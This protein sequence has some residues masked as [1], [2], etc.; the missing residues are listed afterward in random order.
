M[1]IIQMEQRLREAAS[2]R[3]HCPGEVQAG[4]HTPGLAA[5]TG[6]FARIAAANEFTHL[7]PLF[8]ASENFPITD[9]YVELRV[10]HTRGLAQPLLLKQGKTI[11]EEQE[12]RY[13]QHVS[14]HI[15]VHQC[16]NI[17][18]HHRMVILGD[19]G[20]GKTSL[21]KYLCLEIATG[22]SER[23]LVP[24]FVPLRRYWLAKQQDA[25]LNLLHYVADNLLQEGDCPQCREQ[26]AAIEGLL[27]TLSGAEKAHVLFLLDGLDEIATH[28]QAIEAVSADIRQLGERFSWVLTSR[29][30][31]FFGDVGE[32]ICYEVVRLGKAGIE[33]LVSNWFA[34]SQ[35]AHPQS[36]QQLLLSQIDTNPRLRDMAGNPF[37]LTL[38]CH[39]QQQFSSRCLPLHRSD[40]YANILYLIR[41]QLWYVKKNNHLFREAE[42]A[43]LAR[44]CHYLYTDADNVPLQIFEYAHWDR[45]ALPDSPPD[46]DQ[47]FLSS[48]LIH[49]WRQGGDFHFTHLTFQEYLIAVHIA[50]QPFGQVK[51]HLFN[52]HW[53]MVYRFLAGIYS[54]QPDQHNLKALLE[55]V[56]SPVDQMGILYLEAAR[57]LI[58]ANVEDSTALL[59]YDLRECLWQLWTDSADYVRESA[60]EVLALL[61]PGYV[62][63]RLVELQQTCAQEPTSRNQYILL[64]SI[65]LLGLIYGTDADELILD[66][67]QA[68]QDSV[69]AMAIG[70]IAVKNMQHLRQSVID[71]YETDHE[72]HFSL[73]CNV[74]KETRHKVFS[75]CLRPYLQRKPA[76]VERYD[77]VFQALT[78]LGDVGIA[79]DLVQFAE[80]CSVA[81]LSYDLVEA[82]LS[83]HTPACMRWLEKMLQGAE[84][85]LR[86]TLIFHAIRY[87]LLDSARLVDVLVTSEPHYQDVYLTALLENVQKGGRLERVIIQTLLAMVAENSGHSIGALSV[88]EQSGAETLMDGQAL[89]QLKALCRC[90]I[91]HAD[92]ELV[93][94][95]IA[96]LSRFRDIQAYPKIRRLALS[97]NVHGVQSIAIQALRHYADLY[98]QEVRELL[99]ALYRDAHTNRMVAD[100]A[101]TVLAKMDVQA[102][103]RYL[104]NPDTRG[105]ITA[106]CAR[107]GVLLFE[108]SYIDNFGDRH[109]FHTPQAR[110]NP[111]IPAEDQLE[112]LRQA[113]LYALENNI[114][115]KTAANRDSP[116][117]ALFVKPEP[118]INENRFPDGVNVKTGNK[119]LRGEL[120]SAASAQKI[121]NRLRRISP[122][123]F[124]D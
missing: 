121:M 48:R 93:V 65:R 95:S 87:G 17:P 82:L 28:S 85:E 44:F 8:D 66:F 58:E 89:R 119:L 75:T 33:E 57:F 116:L 74:A 90:Y 78:A 97:A 12:E 67:L 110:L 9:M 15:S 54:K 103:F 120:I 62:L 122:E 53:K 6:L 72:R 35:L 100:D 105:A 31:G 91:D 38:L 64:R 21:M 14:R 46:F 19:P 59:G 98:G 79:D 30:T 24:L 32:D 34:N 26:R 73:L 92:A 94:N 25:S 39:I 29:H 7:P 3:G 41:A 108:D 76:N 47:H 20:S 118:G 71:L 22:N 83:L 51:Q 104:D 106:F 10:A 4:K 99:H 50:G 112:Q 124:M 27:R 37:L 107:E 114:V 63:A 123:L 88:L 36:G 18:Q 111:A 16:V 5:L 55:A 61:S 13:K 101:L 56:T 96:I 109:V 102:I 45:F 2:K 86:K 49:S 1:K 40:V 77:L 113:C 84:G 68:D 60:G 43:W 23:W 115:Q 80:S 11:A 81:E 52:P 70:A 117:P 42:M 69:R